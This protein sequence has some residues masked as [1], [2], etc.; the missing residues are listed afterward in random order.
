MPISLLEL[1]AELR[2]QIYELVLLDPEHIRLKSNP[3]ETKMTRLKSKRHEQQALRLSL[4]RVNKVI[5]SEAN[6]IFYSRNE[7]DVTHL[8]PSVVSSILDSM[9]SNASLIRSIRLSFERIKVSRGATYPIIGGNGGE[10]LATLSGRCTRLENI[11]FSVRG[12]IEGDYTRSDLWLLNKDIVFPPE[13]VSDRSLHEQMLEE[14]D[15]YLDLFPELQH[16]VAE[17]VSRKVSAH[18]LKDL[19]RFGFEVKYV[20]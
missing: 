16:L 4:L 13:F 5:N 6:A 19:K 7:F 18:F 2:N 3:R 14:C 20:E 15:E 11:T 17:V 1:S 8:Q 10:M 9:G 12:K